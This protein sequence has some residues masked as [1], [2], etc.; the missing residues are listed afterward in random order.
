MSERYVSVPFFINPLKFP[1][2]ELGFFSP[3]WSEESAMGHLLAFLCPHEMSFDMS[4]CRKR[5]LEAS[6][7]DNDVFLFPE[8]PEL[9]E[10]VFG[11]LRQ[12]KA[13]YVLGNYAGSISLC[14]IVAEKVA[15][16]VYNMNTP[17]ES[18]RAQ[19]ERMGQKSRV[20]TLKTEAL[21]DSESKKDFSDIPSLPTSLIHRLPLEL[22]EGGGGE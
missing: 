14:G 9:K 10:N 19:F 7:K 15:L 18:E 17:D 8:E 1:P 12:A 11:P 5:Y 22:V 4:A 20:E 13:N 3:Q 6:E 16:L 21:I 2:W